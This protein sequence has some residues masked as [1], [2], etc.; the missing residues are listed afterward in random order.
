MPIRENFEFDADD[1]RAEVRN[2]SL[3]TLRYVE[4]AMARKFMTS[5]FSTGAGI[6]GAPFTGGLTLAISWYKGRSTYVAHKKHEIVQDE[7]RRR[8]AT[9]RDISV[10]DAAISL[11]VG[12]AGLAIGTEVGNFVEGVTH[13]DAMGS[14]LPDDA[15]KSTGLTTDPV[16]AAKGAGGQV[17]RLAEYLAGSNGGDGSSGVAAVDQTSYH[18]GMVQ[19]QILE[20]QL[21]SEATEALLVALTAAPV[22]PSPGCARANLR[23]GRLICTLCR[24]DIEEDSVYWHCCACKNDDFDLCLSCRK[25]GDVCYNNN[26]TMTKLVYE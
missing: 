20:E 11:S 16:T 7:L 14:H 25:D 2:Y 22:Q 18:A 26:H 8:A 6:G 17:E 12:A 13:T 10:K 24:D 15:N 3:E 19:A 1:Y 5:S 21:G 9:P 4:T 23:G